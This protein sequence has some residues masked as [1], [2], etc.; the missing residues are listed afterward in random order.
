[1]VLYINQKVTHQKKTEEVY[2]YSGGHFCFSKEISKKLAAEKI[3]MIEL[4]N[5]NLGEKDF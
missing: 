2:F 5:I 1:M 3:L 4:K